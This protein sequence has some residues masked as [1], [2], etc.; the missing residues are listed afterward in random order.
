MGIGGWADTRKR[1]K[2][3]D[4]VVGI[5]EKKLERN[6]GA[7]VCE[8]QQAASLNTTCAP[9]S[10]SQHLLVKYNYNV[11][12]WQKVEKVGIEAAKTTREIIK[13]RLGSEDPS[14]KKEPPRKRVAASTDSVCNARLWRA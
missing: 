7:L 14:N 13:R 4:W 3:K 1:Y 2:R 12:V 10:D 9:R 11:R 8:V 6:G 5:R